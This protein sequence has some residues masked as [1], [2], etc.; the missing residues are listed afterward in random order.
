MFA[1][2][3]GL[4]AL[5]ALPMVVLLHLYRRRFRPKVVSAL[6]LWDMASPSPLSGRTR[7]PLL[8]SA[9]FWCE[10]LAAL[11]LALLLAGPTGCGAARHRVVVLDGSASMSLVAAQARAE[12]RNF[13]G[14]LWRWERATVVVSGQQARVLAG[15]GISPTQ[16]IAALSDWEPAEGS[17]P[18]QEAVELARD[19]ADASGILVI[20]DAPLETEK[21]WVALGK[22]EANIAFV[23]ASRLGEKVV[24]VI[25]NF[26]PATEVELQRFGG[27]TQRQMLSLT[28]GQL[29]TVEQTVPVDIPLSFSL[30]PGGA[31]SLDDHLDL[32]PLPRRSLRLGNSLPGRSLAFG[33]GR[34]AGGLERMAA[35]LPDVTVEDPADLSF[36]AGGGWALIPHEGKGESRPVG[37]LL[38]EASDLTT[39]M[40]LEG[41]IWSAWP[42]VEL[43]GLP[44]VQA[45][46]LPVLTEEVKG[47]SRIIH[48]NLDPAQSN[49]SR[50]PDWPIFLSNLMEAR[51]RALPGP[52][53]TLLRVRE[54]LIWKEAAAGRWQTEDLSMDHPGGELI[55]PGF[56]R[57]GLQQVEGPTAKTAIS[58]ALL[59]ARESDLRSRG[60]GRAEGV[61]SAISGRGEQL[62]L[63]LLCG[64]LGLFFLDIRVLGKQT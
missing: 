4:L 10:I 50:L 3:F 48:I 37:P 51:R 14:G 24:L 39:A 1:D 17:H 16:A 23:Q 7:P 41:A 46:A 5:L 33:L 57:P 34:Q 55:L 30:S 19:V 47:G 45:G 8:R 54:P 42:E 44:L 18:L 36:G 26:G 2:P 9:S 13:L 60:S 62:E 11:L 15:P 58:V 6:F 21:G 31:L 27:E 53:S 32:L 25:G 29:L 40:L 38:V 20:S 52:A 64:I 35:L 49:L 43:P 22:P 63:L 56:A 28:E 61:E 59:D 12:A